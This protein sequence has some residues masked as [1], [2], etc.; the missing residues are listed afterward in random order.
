[1]NN[2]NNSYIYNTKYENCSSKF[3]EKMALFQ[4]NNSYQ[5]SKGGAIYFTYNYPLNEYNIPLF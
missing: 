2:I 5:I 4:K 3:D 1:M